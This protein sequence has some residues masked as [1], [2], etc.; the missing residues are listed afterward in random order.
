MAVP[1]PRPWQILLQRK[2]GKSVLRAQLNEECTTFTLSSPTKSLCLTAE[3]CKCAQAQFPLPKAVLT[4][5]EERGLAG[6]PGAR[7]E[8]PLMCT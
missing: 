7:A 5:P 2:A 6:A 8:I 3:G 4:V 1:L